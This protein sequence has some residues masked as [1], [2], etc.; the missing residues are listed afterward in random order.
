MNVERVGI[1]ESVGAVFPPERL[2]GV[3][4]DLSPEV[5]IVG[6]DP[7]DLEGC[8]GVVTFE[9]REAFLEA[10]AWVHSIQAGVDRFPIEAFER[11]GVALTNSTGIHG[12]SVGEMVVGYMVALAR[13]LPRYV[14]Q[15]GK[16]EWERPAWDRPFA[17]GDE[18][19]CVV[20]L[21]TLGRGIAT[22]AA[23]LGTTVTGVK[24]TVEPVEGVETVHP[25]EDLRTA[26]EDARFVAL[27]VPLT[28]ETR[29]LVGR[30]E[31]DAMRED[32]YLI[33]VA[34][35]QV[36]DERALIEA[37]RGGDIAGA[38]LDVFAAE[39]LP[40]DS[41]L[42]DL[43]NVI[44]TPHVAGSVRSYYEDIA[45]LVRENVGRVVADRSMKNAV[46]RPG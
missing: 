20:G 16:H 11:A 41:P 45:R 27:A 32:A 44:V 22:R 46:V 35:G 6:D 36:V 24:R 43:E 19:L 2:R 42:W 37:L 23:A 29:H 7:A 4:A 28:D 3:L 10:V 8:D 13:D 25:P 26:V 12:Q 1:H 39:P 18:R 30:A 15:S 38:A 33:N 17:V 5:A 31:L 40:D 21:G 14:R 9:H 34:R